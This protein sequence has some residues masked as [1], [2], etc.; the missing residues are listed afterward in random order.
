[1]TLNLN[2][3]LDQLPIYRNYREQRNILD[4]TRNVII[5][6]NPNWGGNL[7]RTND[8]IIYFIQQIIIKGVRERWKGTMIKET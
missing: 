1:M 4:N 7:F 2:K 8:Y 5:K 6:K 3:P